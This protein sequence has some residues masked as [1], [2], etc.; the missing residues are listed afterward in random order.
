MW[1]WNLSFPAFFAGAYLWKV[2]A[3]RHRRLRIWQQGTQALRGAGKVERSHLLSL[4]AKI[5]VRPGPLEMRITGSIGSD[6]KVVVVVEGLA[7]LSGVKIRRKHF[8]LWAKEVETGEEAFDERF[9]VEGP[10][11]SAYALLDETTRHQILRAT[12]DYEPLEI[13]DGR[14]RTEV[15]EEKLPQLLPLLA[16][17]GQ[18]L[19]EPLDLEREIARNAREDPEPGTRLFNLLFLARERP[20]DPV[21]LDAL[22]DACRD[23]SPEVRLRAAIELGEE[24]RD[25]LLRLAESGE[26]D[27]AGARAVSHLAGRLPLERA[28]SLLSEVLQKGLLQTAGACLEALGRHKAAAVD[29]LAQAMA[30]EKGEV[31]AAAATALGATG[32][33]AAEPPL[34][35]AL[36]REESGLRE[37]A[38]AALGQ[39]GTAAA[40]P[41]LRE[42]AERS[43]LDLGLRQAARQAIAGLQS[44]LEGASPGQLTLAETDAGQLSL[45][46][47]EAGQLSLP[48]LAVEPHPLPP[49]E[50]GPP[51]PC[52][53][54]AG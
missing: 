9:L 43:W 30:E 31:A 35:Q 29:V 49:E 25:V 10:L 34:L 52:A 24:G 2:L 27:D 17:I 40:V 53:R 18:R 42:A 41:A 22:R 28:K 32:E 12:A 51:P 33:A 15:S 1:W 50:P 37:A 6:D 14:L 3:T 45:I 16:R 4:R 54:E 36:Q 38:A 39:V 11:L 44:R 26:D 20:G 5:T 23:E 46:R 19:S 8:N 48:A 7:G 13:A 21:T 47:D